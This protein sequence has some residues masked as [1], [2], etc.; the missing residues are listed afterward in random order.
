YFRQ[1]FAQVTNPPIDPL[2]EDCVMSL[3]TPIG[4]EGNPFELSPESAHQIM[5]N[6]PILSQRKLR[7]ILAMEQFREAR[8][9]LKLFFD[10]AA[11]SMRDAVVRLAD[12]AEAAVRDG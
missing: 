12:Q 11:E 7:Q 1:A 6:S 2:R 5:V 4:R 8:A 3:A 9:T 10:P